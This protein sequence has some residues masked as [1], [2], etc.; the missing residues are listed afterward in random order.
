MLPASRG[1]Q[2][3]LVRALVIAL[4]AGCTETVFAA[5]LLLRW[6]ALPDADGYRLYIGTQSRVYTRQQEL[7]PLTADTLGGTVYFLATGFEQGRYFL[8]L[9]AY[10][11]TGESDYS[12]E[13]EALF[14]AVA[15]PVANAGPDVIGVV[16]QTMVIGEADGSTHCVW[17]QRGGPP[18]DLTEPTSCQVSFTA[19]RSGVFDFL[20]IVYDSEGIAS[21]GSARVIVA[22]APVPAASPA[23]CLILVLVLAGVG[24]QGLRHVVACPNG[25]P[26]EG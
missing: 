10:N 6:P 20:L 16:G 22:D 23:L 18:V 7:G 2:L 13:K 1:E 8:A 12:N 21:T 24:W 3:V 14:D 25:A 5:D 26:G 11:S 9:T 15:P 17:L 19:G 4:L